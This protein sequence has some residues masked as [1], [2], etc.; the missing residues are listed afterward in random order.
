[1]KR[2]V[3]FFSVTKEK[4]KGGRR[5][6]RAHL[7]SSFSEKRSL[8]N[9]NIIL[10]PPKPQEGREKAFT[11]IKHVSSSGGEGKERGGRTGFSRHARKKRIV[12]GGFWQEGKGGRERRLYLA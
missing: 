11:I 9:P 6:R 8:K 4:E 2:L 7:L 12:I 5:E 3:L 10:L 1:M